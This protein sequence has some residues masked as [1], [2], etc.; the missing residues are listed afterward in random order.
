MTDL[1]TPPMPAELEA[2]LRDARN[3]LLAAA[4]MVDAYLVGF[5]P[6]AW[7]ECH[8]T[9]IVPTFKIEKGERVDFTTEVDGTPDFN[10]FDRQVGKYAKAAS[11][12]RSML[13]DIYTAS[14]T[15]RTAPEEGEG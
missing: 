11:K 9:Y 6:E 1:L 2:Q 7:A 10:D 14:R 8:R 4:G 13:W 15:E 3:D 5:F 12:L